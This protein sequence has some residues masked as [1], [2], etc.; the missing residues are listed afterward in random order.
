MEKLLH[1]MHLLRIEIPN[2]CSQLSQVIIHATN[3]NK[4][5]KFNLITPYLIISLL[6]IKETEI[7]FK[8]GMCT[9][10]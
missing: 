3:K 8:A 1:Y 9:L 4:Q 2:L 5:N 7:L 10:E 6:K